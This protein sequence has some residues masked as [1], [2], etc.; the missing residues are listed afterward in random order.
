MMTAQYQAALHSYAEGRY[1]EAMQQFSELLYEDPRNPKL[2]IWLGATFRKAGK[3][4]Y[5]KVQY[6]QVLT[7]TDDPDLLDLASTSLAQIQNKLA[8]TGSKSVNQRSIQK[9]E[10]ILHTSNT[11]VLQKDVSPIVSPQ[12]SGLMEDRLSHPVVTDRNL[13]IDDDATLLAVNPDGDVTKPQVTMKVQSANGVVP[14]P[15]AIASLFQKQLPKETQQNKWEEDQASE[16]FICSEDPTEKSTTSSILQDTIAII[17]NGNHNPSQNVNQINQNGKHK[18]DQQNDQTNNPKNK[19]QDKKTKNQRDNRTNI[20][21]SESNALESDPFAVSPANDVPM[22]V[23]DGGRTSSAIALEDILKF[24]TVGQKIT[25]W[26]TLI[27]TIPAVVLGIAA[28]RVGDGLLLSRVKQNQQSEAV[29]IANATGSFLQKQTSDVGVIKTLLFSTEIGQNTLQNSGQIAITTNPSD[30]TNKTVK[31]L[32]S[33]PIAQQRQ[34]KQLLT[35][36]LNLYSQA[37]P[38]YTSIALFSI[39]G[40]LIAQSNSSKTLQ[41]INANTLSKVSTVDNVLIGNPIVRKEGA[42]FYAVAAIK[43]SASQK[44]SMVLQVEIPVKTLTSNLTKSLTNPDGSNFYVIDNSNRY[45]ASSQFVPIG[46]D[47]SSEFAIL[48]SLRSLP[49]SDLPERVKGDRNV[50]ILGYAPVANMQGYGMSW[51]VL[52]TIDKATVIAANQS[53]L[54]VIGSGIAATPLLVAAI[55]YA[56]SRRLSARL[57]D[58]RAAL[59]DLRQGKA[60]NSFAALSTKGNDELA[61]IS[62]SINK[63]SEQFQTMIQKQEQEKQRLQLQVVKLVKV[64]SKLA[65]EDKKEYQDA[66]LSDEKILSLGKKIRG[67]MVQHYAEVESYRKQKED[68]QEQLMQ[69]LRDMQKLADGDLTVATKSIDGNLTDVAIFFDDVMRGL[70]NI[71]GQIKSSAS[72][73]N[74]SLGQNEQAIANL[75]SISQRQVDNVTRS[76]NATQMA[77]LSANEI[78]TH[79]QQVIQS[80]QL[81]AAKVSDSDRSIDAVM[82]KVSA[83]QSTVANTAK[84]VKNLGESSQKITKA[85]SAINEI[86]IKT[87]FLAINATLEASRTGDMGIGFVMVAEEVGELAS[88]SVAATKEVESLLM[89]IQSETNAVMIA[90]ESGS[91]QAAESNTLAIA[92]KD[93]LLQISQ[94][95]QQI[96]ELVASIADATIA[97]VQTSEGVANLMKD[98]SHIANRN[99]DAS[100]EASKFLKTTKKYSGDLQQSLA[101]FKTR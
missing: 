16:P 98:I 25:L 8:H 85:I 46:E 65:R 19:Q 13:T 93:S 54:L 50:Q 62:V 45:I 20:P 71:V 28:Y 96:D 39:N 60:G 67:E 59:W 26:G 91:N 70:Q 55:A 94:I 68:L 87:N 81:V 51:D 53:L 90:V 83:L 27:A 18:D 29:S 30:N 11:T 21:Q 82:A 75:T 63:M 32:G 23:F 57:K 80:S 101:H 61:D 1:E 15:P 89:G 34:Y 35:N 92:A 77:K 37:Y 2:H 95:S 76:L 74:L 9:E 99:L 97:Q 78:A 33:L 64:L 3:I 72:Q 52:T 24:S 40:E 43:S 56:L 100:T 86:A 49:L 22:Q 38:Q 6:Q 69:M 48:S 47:A 36:R 73:V 58:I 7:L 4:E 17:Q 5:A 88:R 31:L 14:P 84:R 44:V 79:S 42:N 66:D 10:G 12:V 41:T